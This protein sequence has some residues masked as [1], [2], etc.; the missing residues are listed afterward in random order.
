MLI[1][2]VTYKPFKT[3]AM[4][5]QN[6][7]NEC[8]VGAMYAFP[9][10]QNTFSLSTPVA[11]LFGMGFAALMSLSLVG[12]GLIVLSAGVLGPLKEFS[13]R[14]KT[15]KVHPESVENVG[16]EPANTNTR[17]KTLNIRRDGVDVED[18]QI[19][20]GLG[21][22][23]VGPQ[24][25]GLDRVLHGA[26]AGKKDY[27][28]PIIPG[29]DKFEGFKAVQAGHVDIEDDES[30]IPAQSG[31]GLFTG[32]AGHYRVAKHGKDLENGLPNQGIVVS[33]ENLDFCHDK[34]FPEKHG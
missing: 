15:V 30:E 24:V 7:Y 28:D 21:D 20:D 4:N 34:Q 18:V 26:R 16:E 23:I 22:E 5:Y 11:E 19:F 33:N 32:G 25:D 3:T 31:Q 9:V 17:A 2:L 6:I 14:F 1:Y 27:R 10:L 12:T 13:G 8:V 29:V